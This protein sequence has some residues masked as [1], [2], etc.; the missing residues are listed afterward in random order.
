M[1]TSPSENQKRH[2]VNIRFSLPF[3]ARRYFL[4][5]VGGSEQR[6]PERRAVERQNNPIK[7][8]TNVIFVAGFAILFYLVGFIAIAIQSSIVEF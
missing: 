6:G 7:S 4:T 2:P 1:V 8:A 5:I 3:L